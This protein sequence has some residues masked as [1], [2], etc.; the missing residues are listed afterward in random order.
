MLEEGIINKE[1]T[2]VKMAEE[3]DNEALIDYPVGI[4]LVPNQDYELVLSFKCKGGYDGGLE[5]IKCNEASIWSVVKRANVVTDTDGT[6]I[7]STDIIEEPELVGFITQSRIDNIMGL[8][9]IEYYQNKYS[10][11]QK[12]D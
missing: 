4:E 12:N 5:I 10:Q 8:D 3:I 9:P 7:L 2:H 1:E 11:T 6:T